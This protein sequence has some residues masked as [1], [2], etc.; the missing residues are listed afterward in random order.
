MKL[1]VTALLLAAFAFAQHP[2][3]KNLKILP[4]DENLIPTM[5]AFSAALGQKCDF[6]HVPGDFASDE[7]H[8]KEVARHMINLAKDINGKFPDG[9]MHVTCY[10]CHRGSTTPA[11][12][13]EA[14]K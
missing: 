3:P 1:T 12:E 8:H 4:A 10:T 11:T 13:P 6:C 2:A 9:K 7:K 5:K 14:A